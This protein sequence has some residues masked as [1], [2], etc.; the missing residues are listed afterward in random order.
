MTAPSSPNEAVAR[1]LR[2]GVILSFGLMAVGV[3]WSVAVPGHPTAA[4]VML[5]GL[6]ATM[7][8]PVARLLVLVYYYWRAGETMY[9]RIAAGVVAV[10]AGS[11]LLGLFHFGTR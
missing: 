2:L 6:L 11:V 1:I 5:A 3:I 10:I 4:R 8:T 7:A 9:A